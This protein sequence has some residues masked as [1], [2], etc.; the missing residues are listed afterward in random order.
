MADT[1]NKAPSLKALGKTWALSLSFKEAK[2]LKRDHG[3]DLLADG[4]DLASI[5]KIDLLLGAALRKA[6]PDVSEDDVFAILDEVGLKPALDALQP[7]LE[8]FLG[9]GSPNA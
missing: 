4:A 6:Q 7:A 1:V 9:V 5:D 3:V 2:A 8:A